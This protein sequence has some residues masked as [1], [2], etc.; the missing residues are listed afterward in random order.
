MRWE[1]IHLA[2]GNTEAPEAKT[3]V[4]NNTV[5]SVYIKF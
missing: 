2:D 4:L 1:N 5:P 3:L